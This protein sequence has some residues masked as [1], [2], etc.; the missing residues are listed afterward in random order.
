VLLWAAPEFDDPSLWPATG[1]IHPAATVRMSKFPEHQVS[2]I[3]KRHEAGSKVAD[4]SAMR[5]TG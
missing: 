3:L 5:W 2:A 1:C 4:L